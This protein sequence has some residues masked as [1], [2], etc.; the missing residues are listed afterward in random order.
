MFS[1]FFR[2]VINSHTRED[3]RIYMTDLYRI[4]I[5]MEFHSYLSS[6]P[7]YCLIPVGIFVPRRQSVLTSKGCGRRR[8]PFSS[9][10]FTL[11]CRGQRVTTETAWVSFGTLSMC[12]PLK[13][14][15]HLP[16]NVGFVS[17]LTLG[18]CSSFHNIVSDSE[19]SISHHLIIMKFNFSFLIADRSVFHRFE[20]PLEH[21]RPSQTEVEQNSVILTCTILP[22]SRLK[23][24]RLLQSVR[25]PILN[26]NLGDVLILQTHSEKICESLY[27]FL[28]SGCTERLINHA[29]NLSSS[30]ESVGILSS[31]LFDTCSFPEIWL[32]GL[33]LLKSLS[34]H[35]TKH[36]E[37][38][39]IRLPCQSI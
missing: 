13:T 29:R 38:E 33:K 16:L 34:N 18:N 4:W 30:K 15:S 39:K 9:L 10:A 6:F 22:G 7:V 32:R 35:R 37:I 17:F 21:T 23:A 24:F 36:I 27:C 20:Q 28:I 11:A 14:L 31:L 19:I 12:F 25:D 3:A 26:R 1:T 2:L 8:S 5:G